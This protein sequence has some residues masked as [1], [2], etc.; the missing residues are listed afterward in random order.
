MAR[1]RKGAAE[2]ATP[3][4][5]APTIES[6]ILLNEADATLIEILREFADR[7]DREWEGPGG[8]PAGTLQRIATDQLERFFLERERSHTM[9]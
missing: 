8:V 3:T 5:P 4:A 1:K 6:P 9:I 2:A 7:M